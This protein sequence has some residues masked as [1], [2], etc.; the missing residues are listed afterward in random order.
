LEAIADHLNKEAD[1]AEAE[2]AEKK[3]R[4]KWSV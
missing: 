3:M 2:D 1:A 4:E